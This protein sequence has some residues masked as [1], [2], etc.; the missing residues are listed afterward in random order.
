MN[1]AFFGKNIENVKKHSDVKLATTE[2]RS[3]YS[4]SEPNYHTAKCFSQNLLSL[5]MKRIRM[6]MNKP[7]MIM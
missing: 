7:G 3:N 1:N 6:L 4:V 5:E 2:A